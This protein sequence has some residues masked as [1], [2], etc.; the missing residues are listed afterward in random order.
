MKKPRVPVFILYPLSFVSY[1]FVL[2]DR[3]SLQYDF[4]PLFRA[5]GQFGLDAVRD[6]KLDGK[7]TPAIVS[8]GVGDFHGGMAVLVV[9]DRSLR[10]QQ[11]VVLFFQDDFGVGAHVSSK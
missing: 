1:P 11:Y 8:L 7:L 9:D 6:T 10:D 2:S 5:I 3:L 4:L